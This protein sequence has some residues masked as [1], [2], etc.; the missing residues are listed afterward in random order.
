MADIAM[1]IALCPAKEIQF[2]SDT[3]QHPGLRL[4]AQGRAHLTGLKSGTWKRP[5]SFTHEEAPSWSWKGF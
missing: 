3:L 2:L 1:K 5:N 4:S